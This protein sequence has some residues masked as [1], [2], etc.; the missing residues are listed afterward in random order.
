VSFVT[1][2][3]III[4]VDSAMESYTSVYADTRSFNGQARKA[5]VAIKRSWAI[6]STPLYIEDARCMAGILAAEHDAWTFD[7]LT[8]F[9]DKG[10]NAGYNHTTP[11]FV[12]NSS[13]ADG[14]YNPES[15]TFSAAAIYTGAG[16]NNIFS[17]ATLA[18]MEGANPCTL[19]Y[20]TGTLTMSGTRKWQGTQSLHFNGAASGSAQ[21]GFYSTATAVTAG[22]TVT[23]S[24]FVYNDGPA[25]ATMRWQVISAGVIADRYIQ[26]PQGG[27]YRFA[28]T[29]VTGNTSLYYQMIESVS[30]SSS[31]WFDSL[32]LEYGAYAT[33]WINPGSSNI[34]SPNGT[35]Y[36][37]PD[38]TSDTSTMTAF[39]GTPAGEFSVA[40]WA[41]WP[42]FDGQRYL[43]VVNNG[44]GGYSAG[45][46]TTAGGALGAFIYNDQNVFITNTT[47][48]IPITYATESWHHIVVNL[49][50][51]PYQASNWM[52]IY[53]DGSL[54]AGTGT[55]AL[56]S[57]MPRLSAYKEITIDMGTTASGPANLINEVRIHPFA[58]SP[59]VVAQLYANPVVPILP[60]LNLKGTITGGTT[61]PVISRAVSVEPM[62]LT[63]NLGPGPGLKT[64]AILSFTL[65]EV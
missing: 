22:Q 27:W 58:I 18:N 1:V 21:A 26:I 2:N 13:A 48:A 50:D 5:N 41:T 3:G 33:P 63:G 12:A 14:G 28:V 24:A 17:P 64:C 52:D 61:V 15:P 30:Q 60:N 32:Q 37:S 16:R 51:S 11:A 65:E 20:A 4:P 23:L 56:S 29:G 25:A 7:D 10:V 42:P 6:K 46:Y 34:G 47:Y 9:S 35:L 45:L 19:L 55:G 44:V 49:R 53:V 40:M 31:L 62:V 54:V 59:N 57:T 36:L 43:W 39:T 8:I 38:T